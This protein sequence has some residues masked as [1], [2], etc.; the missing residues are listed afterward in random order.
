MKKHWLCYVLAVIGLLTVA[1]TSRTVRYVKREQFQMEWDTASPTGKVRIFASLWNR[2]KFRTS[3]I[4]TVIVDDP[5]FPNSLRESIGDTLSG[6]TKCTLF[7]ISGPTPWLDKHGKQLVIY[8]SV[9]PSY[10]PYRYDLLCICRAL[11]VDT[12]AIKDYLDGYDELQD[13]PEL[14]IPELK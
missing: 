7:V 13:I 14:N 9:H 2:A 10:E 12:L 8:E 4:T 1:C 11:G 3:G 6:Q 5:P